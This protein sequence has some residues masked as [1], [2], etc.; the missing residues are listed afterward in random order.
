MIDLLIAGAGPAGLA[1]ALYAHRA[2]LEVLVLETR[3]PP[4]DK[5]CGEGLMPAGVRAL[6]D[7]K[8]SLHGRPL[9]GIQFSNHSRTAIAPF[10]DG[11]GMGVRRTT[12][13]T[14]MLHAVQ[15]AGIEVRRASALPLTQNSSSVS[16]GGISARY[17][18]AADGLHS[19]I[20][21]RLGMTLKPAPRR[22]R[23]G[24][25]QHY[26]CAPWSD[27][28]QV[29]WGKRSE[30]YVTPVADNLVGVA[31]LSSDRRSFSDQLADFPQLLERLPAHAATT[32]R[33]A[34]PLLQ[35]ASGQTAGR[36]LLVGDAAGYIDA[37]TGDGISTAV[38]CAEKLVDCLVLGSPEL[39]EAAYAKSTRDYRRITHTLLAVARNP[40][41][42]PAIVPAA[43]VAPAVFR[44]V[45]NR[46]AR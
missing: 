33:G 29:Y 34:G 17:L 38:K 43:G 11:T 25:R 24:L 10:S 36:I 46:L 40:V 32:T 31:V 44:H 18:A 8:I 20:R 4:I 45:V 30:A 9:R 1:T 22:K 26:E 16:A 19:P 23:W 2:G 39:Y 21:D 7:L 42:R 12:L 5:A 3:Q 28:V 27:M 15:D 14:A 6:T 13:Q 41:L 35:R 37:L